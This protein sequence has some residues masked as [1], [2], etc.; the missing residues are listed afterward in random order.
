VLTE[1]VDNNIEYKLKVRKPEII[2]GTNN[3]GYE[4]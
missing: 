1:V 3:V 4:Y 2:R